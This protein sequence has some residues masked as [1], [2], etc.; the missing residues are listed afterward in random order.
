MVSREDGVEFVW[1]RVW[2]NMR[3]PSRR[4]TLYVG[5]QNFLH[6]NPRMWVDHIWVCTSSCPT[7][8]RACF[9]DWPVFDILIFRGQNR[10]IK[11]PLEKFDSSHPDQRT[12]W[13][14]Q[15]QTRVPIQHDLT[16]SKLFVWIVNIIQLIWTPDSILKTEKYRSSK[17]Q[18]CD[19]RRLTCD[20][21]TPRGSAGSIVAPFPDISKEFFVVKIEK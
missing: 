16:F 3:K 10:V 9:C 1:K 4:A 20:R 13:I 19:S 21:P 2:K 7:T 8:V 14:R 18:N 17:I 5:S 6:D 15:E 12:C 11:P